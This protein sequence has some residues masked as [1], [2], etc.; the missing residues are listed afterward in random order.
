M[1]QEIIEGNKTKKINMKNDLKFRIFDEEQNEFHYWGFIDGGFIPPTKMLFIKHCQNQSEQFTGIKDAF[2]NELYS[3]DIV[4]YDSEDGIVT[5]K[6][7]FKISDDENLF[8]SGFYYE[9]ISIEDNDESDDG[10]PFEIIGNIHQ[11]KETVVCA[12]CDNGKKECIGTC[13]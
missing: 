8:V 4:K 10:I 3:G 5:A 6:V 7:I 11:K 9:I 1:T 12:L 2:D 13:E